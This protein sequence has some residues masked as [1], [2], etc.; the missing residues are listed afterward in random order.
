MYCVNQY[1]KHKE[2]VQYDHICIFKSYIT[3][4]IHVHIYNGGFIEFYLQKH[5]NV[6]L[7]MK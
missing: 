5:L 6:I 7:T 2:H 4:H 3:I 1:Q